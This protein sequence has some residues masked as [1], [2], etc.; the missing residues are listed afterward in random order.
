MHIRKA[1]S[2][3][4]DSILQIY[5]NAF[6]EGEKELVSKLAIDLLS[7]KTMPQTI[8]LVAETD[9]AIVGHIAFSPI[10]INNNDNVLGYILAPLAVMPAY[11]KQGIGTALIENGIQELVKMEVNILFVYGDPE[12]Y[13]RFGFLAKHAKKFMPQHKIQYPF[14]WQAMILNEFVIDSENSNIACV[15]SLNY[16]KL[17]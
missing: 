17:W 15:A 14:G 7:E 2:L 5:L 6:P 10:K 8:S 9:G 12:Y 3:D 1:T 11:Q 16:P 4:R 13:I